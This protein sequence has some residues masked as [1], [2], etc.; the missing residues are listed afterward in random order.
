[1]KLLKDQA[2]AKSA[3]SN[4]QIPVTK[5]NVLAKIWQ[6]FDNCPFYYQQKVGFSLLNGKNKRILFHRF[7]RHHTTKHHNTF[8]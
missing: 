1:L 7:P 2:F 3:K 8:T 4:I 5:I 6:F